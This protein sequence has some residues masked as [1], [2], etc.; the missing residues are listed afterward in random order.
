M[1]R[2]VVKWAELSERGEVRHAV[3][4]DAELVGIPLEGRLFEVV[5]VDGPVELVGEVLDGDPA[6]ISF[7]EGSR[8]A[9]DGIRTGVDKMFED[10]SATRASTRD[11]WRFAATTLPATRGIVASV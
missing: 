7:F 4:R 3:S 8:T 2:P 9:F 1:S 11:C 5:G 6:M 10:M